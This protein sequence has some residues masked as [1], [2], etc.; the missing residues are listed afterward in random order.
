MLREE[1]A[2]PLGVTDELFFAV[3]EEELPRLAK[4][5]DAPFDPSMFEA[6]E[7]A[8]GSEGQFPA[9]EDDH[10][11]WVWAPP[12]CMPDAAFGNRADLLTVDMPAG[13]TTSARAIARMYA[14]L[15]QDVNGVRLISADRLAEV[16]SVAM[17]GPD[18]IF[19]MP[20]RRG[21]GYDLDSVGGPFT[22]DT[23]FG[24]A[25]SGGTAAYADISTRT[26]LAV[27]KNRNSFGTYTSYQQISEAV[28]GGLGQY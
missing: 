14:A 24:F 15:M 25:G 4:L 2:G 7:G 10:D 27:T 8:D 6:P 19:G 16:T 13:C 26:V 18:A 3:P 22:S 11:G 20:V 23:L 21:L 5:E 12:A 28:V 1:V 9:E 17:S